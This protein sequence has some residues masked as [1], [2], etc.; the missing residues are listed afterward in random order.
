MGILDR[1][2][3][4][5]RE[6]KQAARRLRDAVLSAARAPDLYTTGLAADTFDGRFEQVA[7]HGALVMRRLRSTGAEGQALADTLMRELFSV[8]D[9]SLRETGVG[10]TTISRKVRG[11]GERFYGLARGLDKALKKADDA[12]LS[13]FVSRNGLAHGTV[14]AVVQRLRH[15]DDTLARHSEDE[16]LGGQ[17][18][19]SI[20]RSND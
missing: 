1:F 7:L 4:G 16:I 2:S 18:D 14:E 13:A 19:W 12:E 17:L 3:F 11:L 15:I 9:Y 5:N 20:E 10:D 6:H 8:F